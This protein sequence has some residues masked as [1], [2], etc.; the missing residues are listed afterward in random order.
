ML[1]F[2]IGFQDTLGHLRPSASPQVQAE[3]ATEVV[4][5]LI[6]D[7]YKLFPISIDQGL[8]PVGKDTFMV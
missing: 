5:R 6:G 3:A 4:Q 8:G 7:D 2:L 1:L